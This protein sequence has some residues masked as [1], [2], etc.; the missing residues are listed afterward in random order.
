VVSRRALWAS[1]LLHAAV[2]IVLAAMPDE[3][4]ARPDDAPPIVVE[5]LEPAA[6]TTIEAP[7]PVSAP[8]TDPRTAGGAAPDDGPI[9]SVTPRS[10][11]ATQA[12]RGSAAQ[13]DRDGPGTAAIPEADPEHDASAEHREGAV[14]L[15]LRGQRRARTG[16]ATPRPSVVPPSV[17]AAPPLVDDDV[18]R[19]PKDAGFERAGRGRWIY[20]N[21][22]PK[23]RWTAELHADG[24]VRFKDPAFKPCRAEDC[25]VNQKKRLM[26]KTWALRL[27]MAETFARENVDRQLAS[28]GD[29]LLAI[30]RSDRPPHTRRK[31]I[32]ELWDECEEA[33]DESA[34]EV[35]P[36]AIDRARARAGER[37]RAKIIAFIRRQIPQGGADRYTSAELAAFNARRLSRVRFDP[38]ET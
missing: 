24:S 18:V 31:L 32:F 19:T 6:V 4:L 38:Y 27:R 29:E 26:A 8:P 2:A 15:A 7:A 37:A 20:R 25:W 30:W 3:E 22:D 5:L 34:G 16:T 17:G 11:R 23:A 21:P 10:R 33:I 14:A 12:R 36:S 1:L 9:A 35:E 28:L 13:R